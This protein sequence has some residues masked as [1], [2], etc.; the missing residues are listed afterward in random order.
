MYQIAPT[1]ERTAALPKAAMPNLV[2][3]IKSLRKAPV[4]TRVVSE[5]VK[6]PNN[7]P[8]EVR[9]VPPWLGWVQA[10]NAARDTP[11]RGVELE[12]FSGSYVA[13]GTSIDVLIPV[14]HDRHRF[15]CRVLALKENALGY[16]VGVCL[17][18][19]AAIA[20]VRVIERICWLECQLKANAFSRIKIRRARW[21]N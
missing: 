6:H 7:F 8:L 13:V 20:K 4:K 21:L 11:S 10:L 2:L 17:W 1:N 15:R 9:P 5:L 12:F 14:R 18:N 16:T 3:F 19:P